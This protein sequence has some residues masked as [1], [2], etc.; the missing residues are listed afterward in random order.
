MKSRK[1]YPE[2]FKQEAVKL[3]TEQGMSPSQV[4]R[5]LGIGLDTVHR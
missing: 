4:A 2:E 3:L 1:P 5:D